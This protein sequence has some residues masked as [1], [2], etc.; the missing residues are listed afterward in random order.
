MISTTDRL[1]EMDTAFL[2]EE[3]R[4]FCFFIYFLF[5]L[6]TPY[7]TNISHLGKSSNHSKV[8]LGGDTLVVSSPGGVR[9]LHIDQK[10][11]LHSPSLDLAPDTLR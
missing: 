5:F 4:F 9:F 11:F 3:K 1:G 8:P 2:F 6:D 7:K 10:L